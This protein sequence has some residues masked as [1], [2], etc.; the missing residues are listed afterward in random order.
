MHLMKRPTAQ[1]WS[2]WSSTTGWRLK[3]EIATITDVLGNLKPHPDGERALALNTTSTACSVEDFMTKKGLLFVALREI[4]TD[5][6]PVMTGK[7]GAVTLVNEKQKIPTA[8]QG[9]QAVGVHCAAHKLNLAACQA[10][11]A[12]P[13][14]SKIKELLQQLCNF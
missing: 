5:G 7:E 3:S 13:C 12:V 14:V 1:L 4:G 10:A 8:A 2:S 9:F 11:R 6:T